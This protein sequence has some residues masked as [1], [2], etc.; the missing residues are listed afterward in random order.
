[1]TRRL[2]SFDIYAPTIT[3]IV[4]ILLCTPL[5]GQC[6]CVTSS[7]NSQIN[8]SNCPNIEPRVTQWWTVCGVQ[9]P[10]LTARGECCFDSPCPPSLGFPSTIFDGNSCKWEVKHKNRRCALNV[11]C[12]ESGEST[13][14]VFCGNCPDCFRD[15]DCPGGYVC[16]DGQCVSS[17]SDPG[18]CLA[19]FE[20]T[21]TWVVEPDSEPARASRQLAFKLGDFISRP[22]ASVF[23]EEWALVAEGDAGREIKMAS[24]AGFASRAAELL[25]E[26]QKESRPS[27]GVL[28]VE[29]ANHPHNARHVRPPK[30]IPV[31]L[32]LT[33]V[34]ETK[35]GT[36]WFRGEI[37]ESGE[38][39]HLF[40][41]GSESGRSQPEL[42]AALRREL[43]V[44]F[45]NARRHRTVILAAA[46][47]SQ[48]GRVAVD[49]GLALV[50]ACCCEQCPPPLPPGES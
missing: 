38:V 30:L 10:E 8:E 19:G 23:V 13:L 32:S 37:S 44:E 4:L 9:Q 3:L 49:F 22:E 26:L 45:E 39:D 36:Y 48:T 1:M 15:S 18:P 24:T 2:C 27:A 17:P 41:F 34:E 40:V 29:A 14:A 31:T 11:F 20:A 6:D 50:P 35:A 5:R 12:Y 16:Q 7:L 46:R 25:T 33:N 47:V 42:E 28:I 43:R 21:T